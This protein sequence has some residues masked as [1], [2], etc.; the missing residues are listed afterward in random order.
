MYL[1]GMPLMTI[2]SIGTALSTSL[3]S[4]LVWRFVQTF[5]CSGGLS[6]GPAVIGDICRL[7]ERGTYIGQFFGV[8]RVLLWKVTQTDI[9]TILLARLPY[10]DL[11]WHL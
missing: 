11:P 8:G 6:I 9:Q 3:P 5:G 1:Y 2:G 4:L 10:L 7:E